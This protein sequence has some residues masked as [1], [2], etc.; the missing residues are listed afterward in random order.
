MHKENPT[1]VLLGNECY[2]MHKCSKIE[3]EP[4]LFQTISLPNQP[5]DKIKPMDEIFKDAK[6]KE[7]SKVGIVGFKLFRPEMGYDIK[8]MFDLPSYLLDAIIQVV[9]NEDNIINATDMFIHPGTGVRVTITP[10]DVPFLE[11]GAAWSS[12]SVMNILDSLE[13]GK[14]EMDVAQAAEVKGLPLTSHILGQS[15]HR[16]CRRLI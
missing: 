14:T 6:I 3:V 1:Y 7:G 10:D 9:G 4:I 11:Y 13:V 2:V 16:A 8:K 15:G 12:K 5:L